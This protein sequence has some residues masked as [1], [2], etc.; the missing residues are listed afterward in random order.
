MMSVAN[1]DYVRSEAERAKLVI[2]L[3]HGMNDERSEE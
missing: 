1:M 3:D 2:Q